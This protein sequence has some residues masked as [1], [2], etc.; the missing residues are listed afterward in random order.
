VELRQALWPGDSVVALR[1][2]AESILADPDQVCFL[3]CDVGGEPVGFIEG[4]VY[5]GPA[6]PYAHVEGWYVVPEHR[7][8]GHGQ[9]L[10]GSLEHWCLHREICRLTSDTT[11]EYPSSPA[12][13]ARAGFRE[14]K[15]FSIFLKELG[16]ERTP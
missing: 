1:E 9:E 10:L 7:G 3:R 15:R 12:A 16:P 5:Q 8:A 13:H 6:G 4:G 2:E 11:A 14:I